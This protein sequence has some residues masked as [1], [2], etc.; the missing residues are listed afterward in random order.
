MEVMLLKVVEFERE[1]KKLY[2]D[3]EELQM[4]NESIKSQRDILER[5]LRDVY[6]HKQNTDNNILTDN[7]DEDLEN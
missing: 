5:N 1:R 7:D 6:N 2:Q 4:Q 3:M